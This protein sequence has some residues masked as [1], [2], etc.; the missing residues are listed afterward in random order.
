MEQQGVSFFIQD[1]IPKLL[2]KETRE[3]EKE[4]LKT[5]LNI[6]IETRPAGIIGALMAM[7]NREDKTKVLQRWDIPALLIA[8]AKD[9]AVPVEKVFT[10][11]GEHITQT[12]IDEAGH[13]GIF[14]TPE[15]VSEA[16]ISFIE[17]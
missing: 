2:A 15:Q 4:V 1:L 9:E 16:I 7:K 12:V 14:E 5:L 3:N 10:V 8:G 17:N 13:M 6:G 11:S